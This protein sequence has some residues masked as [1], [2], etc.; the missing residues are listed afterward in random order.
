MNGIVIPSFKKEISRDFIFYYMA[1]GPL[2]IFTLTMLAYN[3]PN[4]G[5]AT[6]FPLTPIVA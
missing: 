3:D 1:I 6:T 4:Y 2:V 5:F